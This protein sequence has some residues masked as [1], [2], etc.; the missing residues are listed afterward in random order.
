MK[1]RDILEI[2]GHNRLK[3]VSTTPRKDF[4]ALL[5]LHYNEIAVALFKMKLGSNMRHVNHPCTTGIHFVVRGIDKNED[6]YYQAE[7]EVLDDT[8]VKATLI[9]TRVS[10]DF[11][12][13]ENET[14]DFGDGKS[15]RLR[16]SYR[17]DHDD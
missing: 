17:R 9:P 2:W 1:A 12:W 6:G 10:N 8:W 14:I 7:L 4:R 3:L 13:F 5:E 16:R 11:S 15:L